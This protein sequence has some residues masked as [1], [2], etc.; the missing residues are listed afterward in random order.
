M[1]LRHPSRAAIIPLTAACAAF[2]L[3]APPADAGTAARDGTAVRFAD[4]VGT[5]DN[6]SVTIDSIPLDQ[7]A[8]GLGGWRVSFLQYEPATTPGAGCATG[9]V[10]TVCPRAPRRPRRSASTS[11]T[12]TT[13]S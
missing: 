11:A 1:S 10:S 9:F 3:A 13:V 2:A 12:A 7:D 5:G 8:D 6:L 4:P